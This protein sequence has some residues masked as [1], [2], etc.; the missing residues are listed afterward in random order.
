MAIPVYNGSAIPVMSLRPDWSG[1]FRWRQ[2]YA[3]TITESL[4]GTEERQCR[5]P[6]PLYGLSFRTTALS[7]DETSY[8][9]RL[10][11]K[12]DAMPMAVPLWPL[13]VKLTAAAD[14]TDTSLALDDTEDCLLAVHP[15]ASYPLDAGVFSEFAILW[16]DYDHWE[17]VELDEV[18]ANGATLLA[19]LANNYTSAAVLVPI[20]YGH[21]ARANIE[22]LTDEHGQWECHFIET[23]HRLHDQSVPED[24]IETFDPTPCLVTGITDGG[25][26][27]FDC[28]DD[29]DF[30]ED[31]PVAANGLSAH[32]V[33]DSPFG[34]SFGESFDS[35]ADG[36]LSEGPPGSGA[37][38]ITAVFIGDGP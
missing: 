18:S 4:N 5:Q 35:Y 1:P 28:Y 24:V 32:F 31:L 14:A 26:T 11:E 22:Q 27:T 8:L 33:G 3:T 21:V 30:T 9:R 17:I 12:P 13:A 38:G 25:G 19:G 16:E 7:A 29:G 10:L 2:R 23:F 37:T 36:S 15:E 20:A 6:R 34:R